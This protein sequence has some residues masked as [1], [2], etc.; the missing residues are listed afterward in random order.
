MFL[1]GFIYFQLMILVAYVYIFFFKLCPN[2]SFE[3][4]RYLGAKLLDIYKINLLACCG[5]IVLLLPAQKFKIY[6]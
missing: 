6:I 1:V 4:T 5:F 2:Y 3:V